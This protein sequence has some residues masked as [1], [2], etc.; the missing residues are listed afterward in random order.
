MN[1]T[2]ASTLLPKPR[3]PTPPS[4]VAGL[5]DGRQLFFRALSQALRPPP[6]RSVA[7]WAEAKRYVAAESGTSH[8]GRWSN[9]LAPYM[10]EP[11]EAM[12]L[13]H[14]AGEVT[15][16]KSHQVA[17]TEAAINAVGAAIDEAPCSIL[18]VLPTLDEGKK[19]VK[20]KLQPTIEA[21]PAL[22]TKVYEQKSRDEDGSTTALKKFRG[23]FLQVTGA[24]SSKGLQMVTVRMLVCDEVSEWPFDVDGRGDPVSLA[25]KRT[26]AWEAL[27]YKRVYLSTPGLRGSC[28]I[29]LKYEDS[30]QRRFYVP[31]PQC[32]AY[33]V[34]AWE[35]LRWDRE[36][37][38]HGAA[39]VCPGCG[40]VIEHRHKRAMVG[41]GLWLK[42]YPG[43]GQPPAVVDPGD[44]DRHRGR[45][46]AGRQPGFHIWQA[47]SP[48]VGWDAMVA[49]WLDAQGNGFKMKVFTQQVLGEEYEEKGEAPDHVRLFE[50]REAYPPRRLV[51]GVLFLTGAVDVQ[52]DRLEWAV[53]G[54]GRHLSAWLVDHGVIA[55][56]PVQ[57][58]VWSALD[59][60]IARRYEDAWG[61]P[62]PVDAWGVDTG[63]LSV[64]VY[65]FCRR[66]AA[67]GRVFA[68]DGRSGW[69]LPPIGHY[70][71]RDVDFDG[72]KIGS[73]LLWPV[74]TWD[75]KSETYSA[76]R[77]SIA[78]PDPLTGAWPD[79]AMHFHQGT[80]EDFFRQLTAE[81]LA[82]RETRAGL[83]VKEWKKRGR[84]EQLDL[85]VYARALAHHISDL[86]P[87][88][89]WDELA[90]ERLGQPEAAQL[91]LA[92]F[93]GPGLAK[94]KPAEPPKA[95][96]PD[97]EEVAE[98]P[99]AGEAPPS[100]R[101]VRR[102]WFNRR[103]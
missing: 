19:F 25:E 56:D 75:M 84:N 72:R 53:Y 3:A 58:G 100:A 44:L 40:G 16:K 28:R 49:D 48:F 79:G 57:P 2:A 87:P 68:L 92:R 31:C 15:L 11:M 23:G 101:F 65:A 36:L 64:P 102:D 99:R 61:R 27:G 85:A 43:E 9:D 24:N 35:N 62:W 46:S 71:V 45:S 70:S 8:P 10:V 88:A 17:G 41:A 32:S 93:W 29:A 12:S 6:K 55:G 20:L 30:D 97:R 54:W 74:G 1:S 81:H 34:L 82:D 39:F 26:T 86:L 63:Y 77:L 69:K 90:A 67:P 98:V 38:P 103:P 37:P 59:E 52:D 83:V 51:P 18:Y 96:A 78:G 95:P 4:Q 21:T 22:K 47:Y 76:L 91:D 7:E 5:A 50:R 14:P 94:A 73:V 33:H 89:R 80:D 42:T 66:H 13:W 60:V